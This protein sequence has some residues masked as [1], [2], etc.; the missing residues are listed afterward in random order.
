M[1]KIIQKE[2]VTLNMSEVMKFSMY[3]ISG[4]YEL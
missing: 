3:A 2:M 1:Q 4:Y